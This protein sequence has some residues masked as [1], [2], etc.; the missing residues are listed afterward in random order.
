MSVA[1]YVPPNDLPAP[2]TSGTTIQTFQDIFGEWWV[3]KST[4]NSG[5]WYKARDVLHGMVYRNAAFTPPT[6]NTL[7]A[8]DTVQRDT[9][10]MWSSANY[11]WN[12]PLTGWYRLQVVWGAGAVTSSNYVAVNLYRNGSQFTSMNNIACQATAGNCY[13]RDNILIPPSNAVGGT[14]Y[15][16][17]YY[18]CSLASTSGLAGPGNSRFEIDYVGAP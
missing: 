11:S 17:F 1:T 5:N 16:Q 3:A 10:G 15:F 9:Y 2:V 8:F 4:V 6:A 13:G 12:I 18:L 7:F 14:D